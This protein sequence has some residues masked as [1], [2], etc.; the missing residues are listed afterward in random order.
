M[1]NIIIVRSGMKMLFHSPRS[2]KLYHRKMPASNLAIWDASYLFPF[3]ISHNLK[4]PKRGS[5]NYERVRGILFIR[6]L[7]GA[8]SAGLA[9]PSKPGFSRKQSSLLF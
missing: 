8:F 6:R 3:F 5:L 9:P 1:R 4:S 7:A 2:L